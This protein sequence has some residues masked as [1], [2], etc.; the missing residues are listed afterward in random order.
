MVASIRRAFAE[1]LL[2]VGG[3]IT[4]TNDG[5]SCDTED[6]T[7]RI[8]YVD[9]TDERILV[10]RDDGTRGGGSGGE[11]IVSVDC[12]SNRV[13]VLED[14]VDTTTQIKKSKL[15]VERMFKA[16]VEDVKGFVKENRYVLYWVS[17]I[18]L[19]DHFIFGGELRGK[20]QG[21]F[22]SSIDKVNSK[23]NGESIA[24]TKD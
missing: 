7:G 4:A 12:D 24:D 1:R 2:N 5:D 16:G 8:T 11:W 21:L 10:M 22:N 20:V 13:V 17:L 3:R 19:A 14:E 9:Y 23:I 6:F 15:E 18:L